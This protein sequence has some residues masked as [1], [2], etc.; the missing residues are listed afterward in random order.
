MIEAVLQH[1]EENQDELIG[2][3]LKHLKVHALLLQGPGTSVDVTEVVTTM[4][5]VSTAALFQ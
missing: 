1:A 4:A 3:V 2:F 5:D